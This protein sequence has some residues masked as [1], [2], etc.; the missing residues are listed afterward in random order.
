MRSMEMRGLK[1]MFVQF[2]VPVL[3]TCASAVGADSGPTALQLIETANESVGKENE[4]KVLQIRS[5][6]SIDGLTPNIWQ[7]VYYDRS[8]TFKT[9]VVKFGAGKKLEVNRPLRQPFAYINYKNVMDVSKLKIDSDKAIEIATAEPILEGL[10]LRATQLKLEPSD[11]GPV[12]KVEL[13][14]Q[15]LRRPEK[16]ASIGEVV[17]SAEDGKVIETDLNPGKID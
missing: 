15:R 11:H 10:K 14:A 12:W 5:E 16:D 7:L 3:V 13:W 1:W 17:L 2:A 8:A 9:A 4:N 6:K